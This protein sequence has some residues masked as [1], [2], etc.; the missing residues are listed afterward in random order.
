MD[1][2]LASGTADGMD[3]VDC[4]PAVS[5]GDPI[6]V[7]T[8]EW[9]GHMVEMR[10]DHWNGRLDAALPHGTLSATLGLASNDW[11]AAPLGGGFFSLTTPGAGTQDVLAWASRQPG[12]LSF[13]PDFILHAESLPNDPGFTSQWSLANSASG[14]YGVVGA[15]IHATQAW[16]VTT[17]S[18]SVVV[19]VIDSGIDLTHPDLAANIWTNPGEIAGNG[20]DDDHN[21][22]VDDVHGWNFVTNTNDV[23]DGYGHGTHVSGIIGAVGNNGV[24]VSGINW[25]VSI[26]PLK[27]QDDSGLG[28]TG[29][30]IAALNYATMMRRDYGINIVVTSNSWGNTVGLSEMLRDAIRAH[31]E[32]GITFVAAAGNSGVDCDAS[33]RYPA[34]FD[35][36]NVISVAATDRYDRLASFSNYGAASIDLGA[37]GVSIYSTRPNGSYGSMSGT[38]QAAP[39]V[40]G[41]VALLAAARPGITV[42]QVRA[43]ILG[44][45][46]PLPALAGKTA[47]GGRLNAAAALASLAGTSFAARA[48]VGTSQAVT[49]AIDSITIAFNAPVASGFDLADLL[50]TRDGAAV[51]LGGATLTTSDNLVW[52]VTGLAPVTAPVGR[53]ALGLSGPVATSGITGT[54]GVPLAFFMGANWLRDNRL[55]IGV[56]DAAT[57]V[58]VT[59]WAID[60]NAVDRPATVQLLVDGRLFTTVAAAGSRPDLLATH[61]SANL[62][63]AIAMPPLPIGNHTIEIRVLDPQTGLFSSLGTRIVAVR[64]PVGAVEVATVGRVA[65]WAFSSRAGAAPIAVRVVI[66]GRV[67]GS[68]PA[69]APRPDLE[70][71]LGSANHGY[72]VQIDPAAFGRVWNVVRVWAIDPLTGRATL[73]G[74]RWVKR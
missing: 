59:G 18:R 33:P 34:C 17:G 9:Q 41:V 25:Q 20:F 43:A 14:G 56:I 52:T 73:L 4:P 74:T 66:N 46:D 44:S 47:S 45:V 50:L 23:Q 15:D 68:F 40:A 35:L 67:Y 37:P 49:G 39:Q 27:F 5:L 51:S 2:G 7:A 29:G 16:D 10:T 54:D 21:G 26:L 30:A 72:D 36:P 58:A 13:E 62:G 71:Q 63:Y 28:N 42:A 31:G 6:A 38:S 12:L 55:P 53:Y 57:P 64:A 69:A 65:G 8:V 1:A 22:F 60:P 32:A 11:L 61:G 3:A 24:G 19:G 70:S 48:R